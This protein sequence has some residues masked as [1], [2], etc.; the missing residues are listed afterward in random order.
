MKKKRPKQNSPVQKTQSIQKSKLSDSQK[1]PALDAPTQPSINSQQP[2]KASFLPE[3]GPSREEGEPTQRKVQRIDLTREAL[4]PGITGGVVRAELLSSPDPPNREVGASKRR[5][6]SYSFPLREALMIQISRIFDERGWTQKQAAEFLGVT[7]PRISD[8]ARARIENF[9]ID[10]LVDWLGALG[11]QVSIQFKE[12]ESQIPFF[13]QMQFSATEDAISYYTKAITIDPLTFKSYLKRGDAYFSDGKYDL[14]I[15]D[16]TR[17]MEFSEDVSFIRLRRAIACNQ[18]GQYLAALHDCEIVLNKLLVPDD[19]EYFSELSGKSLVQM[20]FK[21]GRLAKSTTLD[22]ELMSWS[23]LTKARALSELDRTGEAIEC[24]VIATGLFPDFAPAHFELGCTYEAVNAFDGALRCLSRACQI[25]PANVRFREHLSALEKKR[26]PK[27]ETLENRELD[28]LS[29]DI[30]AAQTIPQLAYGYRVRGLSYHQA[31]QFTHAVSD[32]VKAMELDPPHND[33]VWSYIV[34]GRFMSG[35][36]QGTLRD[37][38][39]VI[40]TPGRTPE[41]LSGAHMYKGWALEKMGHDLD[42][43]KTYDEGI[44]KNPRD[45][46]LTWA[47]GILY[48]K[49][50]RAQEALADYR[51]TIELAGPAMRQDPT[52]YTDQVQLYIDRLEGTIKRGQHRFE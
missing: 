29:A 32:L 23:L 39:K 7:Q 31:G 33:W 1:H 14:A 5:D 12:S 21:N 2:T 45:S 19:I 52:G 46:S 6:S 41:D 15:G 48:E 50:G 34:D 51:K 38:D 13:D 30:E 16:Y 10:L 27:V 3:I 47:R 26:S 35:D 25:D 43:L 49:M 20:Q 42:A 18:L 8:L 36:L 22:S 44:R 9:T 40:A 28:D 17:A 37:C 4:P 24:L 11:Q